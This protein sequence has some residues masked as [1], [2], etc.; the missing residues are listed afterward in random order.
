MKNLNHTPETEEYGIRSF[1]YNARDPFDPEKINAFFNEDLEGVIRSKGF[2]WIATR[3]DF[4]GEYSQAGSVTRHQGMGRWWA[5]VSKDKWPLSTEFEQMI[6]KHWVKQY[7]D[8][9]Q[10]IVFIG[11]SNLMDE[12][13]IRERLDRCLINNYFST[14]EVCQGLSDPFPAWFSEASL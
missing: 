12:Q 3:P 14:P 7:G 2:F 5:A 13:R 4:V 10:E 8:R 1:V 9:R 11:F 6:K